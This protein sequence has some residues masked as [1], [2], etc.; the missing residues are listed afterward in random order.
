MV[1]ALRRIPG[2]SVLKNRPA[3]DYALMTVGVI[4]V[5]LGLDMFLIPN[6]LAAGGVSGLA[7]II[8]YVAQDAGIY[9]PVGV[10]MLVM[11]IFLL[12]IGL[13][14]Q[15]WRYAAKTVYGIVTLSIAVDLLAPYVP[16]LA[17][18]DPLLAAL[19]GGALVGLGLGLVF[20]GGGNTGG[21]DIIAQ[22]LSKRVP[23]GVGQL[24]LIVDAM[25]TLLAA[26]V[27]GPELALYG[28]VAI[29][30]QGAVIDLVLEGLR[31]EKA[32]FII[33]SRPK[34]LA[35]A[36][37]FDLNRGATLVPARGAYSGDER[38]MIFTV[39]SRTQIATLK[40]LVAAVDPHAMLVISDV[41]EAFGEGFREMGA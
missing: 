28:A 23:L 17:Q 11:N 31:L 25:V 35:D 20:R 13:R 6:Q 5:A 26:F 7:T 34:E 4:L 39:V 8:F 1:S 10:Q 2:R 19:Y 40:R 38:E 36:V 33:S 18:G 32:A 41:H 14:S 22:L 27:F 12:F 37:L 24:M 3:R 9:L 15:G 29:F 21:T 16:H 30:V